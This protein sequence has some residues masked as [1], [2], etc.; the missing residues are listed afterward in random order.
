MHVTRCR[1]ALHGGRRAA[2]HARVVEGRLA[3]AR[4]RS[5]SRAGSSTTSAARAG[6]FT[7][8]AKLVVLAAGARHTPGI[9][10]RSWRAR[11][12]RSAAACTRT[13]TRSAS[14]CSTSASTRGSART[15]RSTSTTS[16]S[17]GIL[18]GYA[19][20][21]PG[22]LAA[23]MPGLGPENAE[24]MALY[25]HMLTAATLVEDETEGRI[26]IGPRPRALHGADARRRPTSSGS[27]AASRSRPSCSSRRARARCFTPF[28]DLPTLEG[29]GELPR[30]ASRPRVPRHDR[31]HD[32]AHHGH[33]AHGERCGAA[34]GPTHRAPSSA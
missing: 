31:A 29:P 18:I 17:E 5:A 8:R 7:V 26:V 14:A 20:I 11:A 19:A 32:R 15:R 3:A 27:T 10:K 9:L 12:T 2:D 30:I 25:N 28:A 13:R 23:A 6:S 16:S 21:P 34:A 33:R 4:A 24:K 1:R 22:L